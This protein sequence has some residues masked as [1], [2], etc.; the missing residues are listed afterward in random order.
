MQNAGAASPRLSSIR[1]VV[2]EMVTE[3]LIGNNLRF[4]RYAKG[5]RIIFLVRPN[6]RHPIR[7]AVGYT[8]I[9]GDDVS[10]VTRLGTWKQR[11]ELHIGDPNFTRH[12][13]TALHRYDFLFEPSSQAVI[14]FVQMR[15][16]Q[17]VFVDG[18]PL[19]FMTVTDGQVVVR[20]MQGAKL[21]TA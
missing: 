14:D 7:A 2:A 11:S 20:D 8:V 4:R 21:P 5:G 17:L 19:G 1:P 9:V 10:L 18:A 16:T 3:V 6:T 12:L 13:E 15:G